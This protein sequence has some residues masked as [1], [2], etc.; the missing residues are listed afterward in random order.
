MV[1]TNSRLTEPENSI[2][3]TFWVLQNNTIQFH[4]HNS[5]LFNSA[6]LK[7]YAMQTKA[8]E[9]DSVPFE[10]NSTHQLIWTVLNSPHHN[11]IQHLISTQRNST[12]QLNLTQQL[13]FNSIELTSTR[14]NSL[15]P[16]LTQVSST[17]LF[18]R[19]C[20]ARIERHTVAIICISLSI[21]L[22]LSK[23]T[24][25]PFSVLL[26]SFF[27]LWALKKFTELIPE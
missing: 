14:F 9:L 2:L 18:C 8:T 12:Q 17:R 21:S 22:S 16:N 10:L 19:L 26:H 13:P 3:L 24:L 1:P 23:R 5:T 4:P 25:F 6:Q 7:L 15:Q 11:S 20:S 27:I